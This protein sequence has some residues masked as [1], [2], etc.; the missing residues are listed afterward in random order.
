VFDEVLGAVFRAIG[1]PS[2]F[3]GELTVRF[4][5]PAPLNTELE[6][7]ARQVSVEG[8]RRI[9]EGEA[10]SP[11]GQFAKASG[12]FIEMKPEQLPDLPEQP[13]RG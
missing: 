11:D 1:S 12:I 7:R 13:P 6:F 10:R 9:L 5:A 4:E 8:R 3:T 2:A